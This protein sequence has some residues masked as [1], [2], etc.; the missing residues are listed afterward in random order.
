MRV[1]SN[2]RLR[3]IIGKIIGKTKQNK[4]PSTSPKKNIRKYF[5][6]KSPSKWQQAYPQRS[7]WMGY[8]YHKNHIAVAHLNWEAGITVKLSGRLLAQHVWS[9]SPDTT[10]KQTKPWISSITKYSIVKL[11]WGILPTRF[12]WRKSLVNQS[13]LTSNSTPTP[14]LPPKY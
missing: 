8:Q 13:S 11:P 7:I 2:S 10:T 9:P 1:C 5:Y 6:W 14:P 12:F 4:P 3:K